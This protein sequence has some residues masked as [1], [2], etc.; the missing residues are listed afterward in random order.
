MPAVP[1]ASSIRDCLNQNVADLPHPRRIQ[2]PS[3]QR[4]SPAFK[5]RSSR[6]K[7]IEVRRAEEPAA[8]HREGD[9]KEASIRNRVG[10]DL[11]R[12]RPALPR[13]GIRLGT[14]LLGVSI[15]MMGF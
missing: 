6:P 7:V 10:Y 2:Q 15:P 5:F 8:E 13:C 9:A 3:S 4:P 1:W 11:S 14:Y 12:L